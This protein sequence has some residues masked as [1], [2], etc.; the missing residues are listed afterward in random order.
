MK[1]LCSLLSPSLNMGKWGAVPG[2]VCM[3]S[4]CFFYADVKILMT[5]HDSRVG[6]RA[7]SWVCGGMFF[8]VLVVL[9]KGFSF[10]LECFWGLRRGLTL[11][12]SIVTPSLLLNPRLQPPSLD[13]EETNRVY[14]PTTRGLGQHSECKWRAEMIISADEDLTKVYACTQC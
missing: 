6:I 2:T 7:P 9:V 8:W 12:L 11:L 10:T 5:G 3:C 4:V 13:K 1:D 14:N